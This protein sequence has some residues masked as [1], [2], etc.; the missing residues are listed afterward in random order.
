MTDATPALQ[1]K[2][3]REAAQHALELGSEGGDTLSSLWPLCWCIHPTASLL[4]M[5]MS[6]TVLRSPCAGRC[7]GC[8]QPARRCVPASR[9]V[10][11]LKAAGRGGK[12]RRDPRCRGEQRKWLLTGMDVSDNDAI[13]GCACKVSAA[14]T[15]QACN[16]ACEWMTCSHPARLQENAT[17]III[18]QPL[19]A[20]YPNTRFEGDQGDPGSLMVSYQPC[21]SQGLHAPTHHSMVGRLLRRSGSFPHVPSMQLQAS[22][23][24]SGRPGAASWPSSE[25][26]HCAMCMCNVHV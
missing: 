19:S 15:W 16:A 14:T 10:P 20:V 4:A 5:H 1:V 8:K 25:L 26:R 21:S 2:R 6:H 24:R 17:R 9:L 13:S 12:R 11:A 22:C 18:S 7:R 3:D 23:S